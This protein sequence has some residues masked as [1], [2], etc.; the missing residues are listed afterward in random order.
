VLGGMPLVGFDR[1]AV[2]RAM[3]QVKPVSS[4]R[5]EFAYINVAFLWAAAL[6][7]KQ[8]GRPWEDNLD[9]RIFKPLG[10]SH[11]SATKERYLREED[12]ATL[13]TR[14]DDDP[15]AEILALDPDWPYYDWVYVMGPAGSIGSNIPDMSRWLRMVINEG[16]HGDRV[17]IKPE[18]LNYMLTPK[19]IAKAG[20]TG[21]RLYYCLAWVYNSYRPHPFVWH[22]GTTFGAHSVISFMPEE[23]IG[24]VVL[25]NLRGHKVPEA[26]M[27]KFYDLYFQNPERDWSAE[28]LAEDRAAA[29]EVKK[30]N[31]RP[32]NPLPSRPLAH[33][34]GVF[35]NEVY[36]QVEVRENGGRLSVV[37]GPAPVVMPLE[38][39][40]GDVFWGTIPGFST[41]PDFVRFRMDPDG[42]AGQIVLDAFNEGQAGIFNRLD[43]EE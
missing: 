5:S 38:P 2:K 19:T 33:Y 32:E 35:E 30:E 22:N 37:I 21:E 41:L 25:T 42:R 7:E 40:N 34:T 9:E 18:N 20:L 28:M 15:D 27:K 29:A 31:Q 16:R 8:T 23:K 4:F 17:I 24:L 13:H 39:Y 10:M 12:K 43:Q 1:E 14:Q 11:S 3:G 36:G 6:V 26:L